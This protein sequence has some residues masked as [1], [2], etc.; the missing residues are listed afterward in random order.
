MQNTFIEKNLSKYF[1]NYYI[2]RTSSGTG[3]L[4]A[5]LKTLSVESKKNEVIIPSV[6]CPSVMFAV[7]FLGL[8]PIFIDMEV[9]Y[10]NMCVK[11]LKK[12]ISKKTLA[13]IAVHCFGLT[14]AIE[15]LIRISKDKKIFLI[16]DA[17]LNFGGKFKNKYFG[18]FGDAS[19]LSFGYDK[20]LS[21]NGGALMIKSKKKF[22][23]AKKFLRKNSEFFDFQFDEKKFQIKFDKLEE[24]IEIRKKNAK[25]FFSNLNSKYL[26]K[27]NFRSEDVYWRYPV[28]YK[29]NREKLVEKANKKQLIITKHYPAINRFQ[30]NSNLKIA[31]LMDGSILNFFIKPG[32]S[33][34]Y[35]KDLCLLLKNEK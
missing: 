29:R 15:A 2:S 23:F 22:L 12:K 18:S 25:F 6:V 8:K 3:A 13:I 21:E 14:A 19:I 17:C 32:T 31:S 11:D 33:K 4:I 9:K 10:F 5:I 20:I 35:I 34:K 7:N 27:P 16:E 28:I 26:I 30:S 1:H 24:E